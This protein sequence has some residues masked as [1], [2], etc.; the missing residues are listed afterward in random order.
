MYIKSFFLVS[1]RFYSYKDKPTSWKGQ[2]ILP[3]FLHNWPVVRQCW[4][5]GTISTEKG[6]RNSSTKQ[7]TTPSSTLNWVTSDSGHTV[8]PPGNNEQLWASC[9]FSESRMKAND[10]PIINTNNNTY[11]T[12]DSTYETK[13]FDL[14]F[15]WMK[16]NV[17]FLKDNSYSTL[18]YSLFGLYN[19]IKTPQN[20]L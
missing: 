10:S 16:Y 13:P 12:V 5:V 3:Y 15:S 2:V 19:K 6:H 18:R 20:S 8:N 17:Q 9:Y 1:L 7:Y 14:T 4:G 11:K